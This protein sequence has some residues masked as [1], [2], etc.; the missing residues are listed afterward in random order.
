MCNNGK[1]V[2][3]WDDTELCECDS[4]FKFDP[5]G[6]NCI[7]YVGPACNLGMVW[8][9]KTSKIFKPKIPSQTCADLY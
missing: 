6:K 1:C 7:N 4:G 2:K 8:K 9:Q 3:D 5:V